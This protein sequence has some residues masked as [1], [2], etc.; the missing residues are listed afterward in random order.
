MGLTC[1]DLL[2]SG[3]QD[4]LTPDFSTPLGS[5]VEEFMVEKSGVEA[6]G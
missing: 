2:E 3:L 4:I 6:W 1:P 5:G